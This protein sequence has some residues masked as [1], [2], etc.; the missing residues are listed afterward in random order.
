MTQ[1]FAFGI[2]ILGKLL[3]KPLKIK[4]KNVE[5]GHRKQCEKFWKAEN[6]KVKLLMLS[7]T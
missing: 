5:T 2:S 6:I 1:K 3:D 7:R 4:E